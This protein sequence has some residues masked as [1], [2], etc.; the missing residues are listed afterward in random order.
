VE[1]NVK[2]VPRTFSEMQ[3][4]FSEHY[5]AE[6]LRYLSAQVAKKRTF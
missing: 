6:S 3:Q 1:W 5:N 4:I 2:K